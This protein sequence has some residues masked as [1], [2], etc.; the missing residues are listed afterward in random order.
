M[1]PKAGG[2]VGKRGRRGRRTRDENKEVPRDPTR[3][4]KAQGRRGKD[5]VARKDGTRK[6]ENR[7]CNRRHRPILRGMGVRRLGGGGVCPQPC[8]FFATAF[9]VTP[10]SR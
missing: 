6:S 3:P 5:E 1:P 7:S 10:R 2:V 9:R 4:M 8:R